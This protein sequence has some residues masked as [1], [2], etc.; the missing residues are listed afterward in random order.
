MKSLPIR[1]RYGYL[2]PLDIKSLSIRS[3]YSYLLPVHMISGS[4][5]S[6]GPSEAGGGANLLTFVHF[7]SEKLCKSQG[8]KN[9]DSNSYIFEEATRIYQKCNIFDVIQVK[10]FK[11]FM[12]RP[13]LMT[14]SLLFPCA[15]LHDYGAS[16]NADSQY[17]SEKIWPYLGPKLSNFFSTNQ[18]A[19]F[20]NYL[21]YGVNVIEF[22]TLINCDPAHFPKMGRFPTI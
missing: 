11:I 2:L 16:V 8:R 18:I 17:Y 14:M 19:R 15:L 10:N 13:R 20:V 7:V 21:C 12:E 9:E 3:R 4:T 22:S 1:S 6:T 5:R